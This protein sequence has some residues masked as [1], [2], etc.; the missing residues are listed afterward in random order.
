MS[1]NDDGRP[2]V[3]VVA[4]SL[5]ILG[6]Q[7]MVAR[8]LLDGLRQEGHRVRLVPINFAFPAGLRPLRCLPYVRT[9]LN[10]A[11]YLPG[12]LRLRSA[13]IVH[14]FSTS[15]WSFLLA[16]APAMLAARAFGKRVV[17]HYHSGEAEDHLSSWGKGVHPWLR[18]AHTI[19]VPSEYLRSVFARHGYAPVVIPNHL[20]L[21]RFP[22]RER[23][24]LRPRLLSV[25]NLE[26]HYAVHNSIVAC[27]LLR[28]HS[29][30]ASLT[31]AGSGSREARLR[32]LANALHARVRFAGRIERPEMPA[33]YED[34]DVFVNS[35]VV[36]SQPVSVL[37][38]FA[39]G[40]PVV[41][42]PAGDIPA[43]VRHGETGLLVPPED[44]A[45]MV[46]AVRWLL[47]APDEAARMA[48]RARR[49]VEGFTW[50]RVRE[51]WSSVYAG[52]AA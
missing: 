5:D 9:L 32:R 15:C 25:R 48:R 47:D 7:G 20:E 2:R 13:D 10:Q 40:L 50:E 4:A 27:A 23:A 18:L 44:P 22:Y 41:T 29:P 45:A 24:A 30:D 36:D 21:A 11:L 31:V 3:A 14:V 26:G 33:L 1:T 39:A 19:V 35:S 38:A 42:T 51:R 34:A 16:P 8:D 28:A 6:G 49:L 43:L 17:L 46:R 37:E 12:L 52:S